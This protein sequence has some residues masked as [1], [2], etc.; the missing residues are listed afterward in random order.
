M[1][2]IRGF[3]GTRGQSVY[4]H[5]VDFILDGRHNLFV[6]TILREIAIKLQT[7]YIAIQMYKHVLSTNLSPFYGHMGGMERDPISDIRPL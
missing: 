1:Q 4:V 5:I 6:W 7:R 2:N 3:L